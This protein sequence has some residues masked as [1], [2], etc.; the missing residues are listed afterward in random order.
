MLCAVFKAGCASAQCPNILSALTSVCT[1][2]SSVPRLSV[3]AARLNVLAVSS[4]RIWY[5]FICTDG[6]VSTHLL[7][8][9]VLTGGYGATRK[10]PSTASFSTRFARVALH[11]LSFAHIE[12]CVSRSQTLSAVAHTH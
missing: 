3:S 5:T 6:I 4:E 1:L 8:S 12:G 9:S 10:A 2:R 11:R 7:R